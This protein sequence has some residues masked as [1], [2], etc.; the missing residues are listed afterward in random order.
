MPNATQLNARQVQ[1]FRR[2]PPYDLRWPNSD[3]V[4]TAHTG[5]YSQ[6][7]QAIVCVMRPF[8]WIRIPYN[9][10]QMEMVFT[11][12]IPLK[13]CADNLVIHAEPKFSGFRHHSPRCAAHKYIAFSL[14]TH[15]H[16]IA[17]Q[18]PAIITKRDHFKYIVCLCVCA[19]LR[20]W[21]RMYFI[22]AKWIIS[23]VDFESEQM[24][25][26]MPD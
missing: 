26:P 3:A 8:G 4:R 22:F 5:I 14:P 1:H 21:G 9:K 12:I 2:S 16:T 6:Y 24:A 11:K 7:E 23:F 13:F 18:P 17:K 25:D 10:S 20:G 15:I 19:R